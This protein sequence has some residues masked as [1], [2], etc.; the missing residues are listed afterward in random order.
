MAPSLRDANHSKAFK[1]LKG[2]TCSI[3]NDSTATHH[4]VKANEGLDDDE[5]GKTQCIKQARRRR[6]FLRL[7]VLPSGPW[8]FTP[9][10]QMNWPRDDW[11]TICPNA[12]EGE[13]KSAH[14]FFVIAAL[15]LAFIACL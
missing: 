11:T 4:R 14:S 10:F 1:E 15:K 2:N 5:D 13:T 9:I 3:I 6:V 12:G 8:A 7:R